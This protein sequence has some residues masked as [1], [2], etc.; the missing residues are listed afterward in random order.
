ML[1]HTVTITGAD[2]ATN[3]RDLV[4][5]STEFP[6]VEW[7]IL[8]S[9][10]QEGGPRFPSRAWIDEL[11]EAMRRRRLRIAMHLCGR[12]MRELLIGELQWDELP[13]VANFAQTFQFN[14]HGTTVNPSERGFLVKLAQKRALRTFIFQ[15][16]PFSE[17]LARLAHAN[18]F[19]VSGLFDN[20]GGAGVLPDSWPS[21]HDIPF[22]MGF[23]GG[24]GPDNVLTELDKIEASCSGRPFAT[25]IDMEGRV[26][27]EDKSTL[28]LGRVRRVL[29]L[30]AGSR[31]IPRFSAAS[32]AL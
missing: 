5:L 18:G 3:I 2:D 24:L 19:H 26:R 28:D 17:P 21:P 25:W 22:P 7:G 13:S 11:G 20:S 8:V 12:W 15:W 23:A 29:A 14:T 6:F 10:S 9:K 30:V 32:R 31:F 1:L 4:Y 16:N 27:T